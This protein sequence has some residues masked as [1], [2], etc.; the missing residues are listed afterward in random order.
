MSKI[1]ENTTISNEEME[2]I[3][4]ILNPLLFDRLN[5]LSIEYSTSINLLVNFAVQRLTDD[6]DFIRNLRIGK[7][8]LK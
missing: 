4:H 1:L 6:I 2:I 7:V 3:I 8:E 5:I